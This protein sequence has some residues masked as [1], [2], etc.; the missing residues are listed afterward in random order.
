[1]T[2]SKERQIVRIRAPEVAEPADGRFSNCLLAGGIAY[3]AGMTSRDG[4]NVY[5]QAKNIFEKI[6]LLVEQAGGTMAD[7]VKITVYV[8][9]INQRDGVHRARQEYF[10]GDFPTATTIQVVALADPAYKVEI[11]AIAHIGA[12]QR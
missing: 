4:D 8:V 1:M 10:G 9:D 3:I 5:A 6:K 12:S 7:V 11:D 2:A